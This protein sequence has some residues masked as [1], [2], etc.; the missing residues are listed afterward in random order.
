MT[1]GQHY[2]KSSFRGIAMK[3]VRCRAHVYK[4]ELLRRTGRTKGGFER[5][6]TRHQ[7]RRTSIA[8]RRTCWQHGD[9]NP[10]LICGHWANED[11]YCHEK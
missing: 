11:C 9:R 7:C 1:S 2:P 8:G 4:P 5:H 6:Y 10:M 3:K